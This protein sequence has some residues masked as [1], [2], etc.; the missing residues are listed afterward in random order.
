MFD[1]TIRELGSTTPSITTATPNLV[2]STDG[3]TATFVDV[4]GDLVTVKRTA[5]AFSM[6]EFQ[7]TPTAAL[8]GLFA[9][10]TLTA[11]P[12]NALFNVTISAKVGPTGGN[13]FVNVGEIDADGI[14]VGAITVGGE[15]QGL[16]VGNNDD[17]VKALG[18]L[19]VQSLGEVGGTSQFGDEIN[20]EH[21]LGSITVKTDIRGTSI[22]SN[23]QDSGNLSSLTVGGSV[24][25]ATIQSAAGIGSIT[26]GGSFRDGGRI[27]AVN[28]VSAVSIGG[29][30]SGTIV[31]I[32]GDS[33]NGAKG[34]DLLLKTLTV[35]GNVEK[36]NVILGRNNNADASIAS[37]SVGREWL[38]SSILSGIDKGTDGFAG[39][40]DDIKVALGGPIDGAARL[41]TIAS[42]LIKG[43]A[44]GTPATGDHFGIV[45]E[46]IGKAKI[47][48]VSYGFKPTTNELFAA[49]PTGPGKGLS[50][51]ETFD[52]YIREL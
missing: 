2:I 47:G 25:R 14:D 51:F 49:A 42:I 45:A 8:G 34:P 39:T 32:F 44:L 16:E 10:L 33:A 41:S 12:K 7:I 30:L 24:S 26:I 48:S 27:Q 37:V 5:G 31:E 38:A 28:R 50:P 18:S 35:G 1:F 6:G 22:F 43:Q 52:F 15:L 11:A 13:G 46:V 21:G 23:H 40:Q 36:T 9:K 4:D 17:T 20:G 19:T 29:D 3:K